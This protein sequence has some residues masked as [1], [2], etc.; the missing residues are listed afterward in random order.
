MVMQYWG[1]ICFFRVT[2]VFGDP[3]EGPIEEV[4]PTFLTATPLGK[5]RE[6]DYL[7]N[8]IL[9]ESGEQATSMTKTYEI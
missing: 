3:V 7:T 9:R 1:P 5:L 4:T 6:V 8:E 2:W